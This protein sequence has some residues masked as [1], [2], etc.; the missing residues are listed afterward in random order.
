MQV[1][2][3]TVLLVVGTGRQK[4]SQDAD[5]DDLGNRLVVGHVSF[6]KVFNWVSGAEIEAWRL[7]VCVEE[8][9]HVLLEVKV[10][11]VFGNIFTL[12]SGT[13]LGI[14]DRRTRLS[15]EEDPHV[16][17]KNDQNFANWDDG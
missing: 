3:A 7:V 9:V 16:N 4:H 6:V 13:L 1:N 10:V 2:S 12:A 5:D 17:V 8:Q 11:L 15:A 14:W